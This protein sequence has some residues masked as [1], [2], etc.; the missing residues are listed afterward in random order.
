MRRN[1][2]LTVLGLIALPLLLAAQ[3]RKS[4]VDWQPLLW[5]VGDWTGTG[6]GD[7]GHGSGGF[8]FNQDLQG[9]VLIR[10]SFSEY[11]ATA[12][13]PA[14][15]HDDLM[16]IYPAGKDFRAE[17]FDNEGHVIRYAIAISKDAST[18]TFLSDKAAPGPRFRITYHENSANSLT[19]TFEIAPRDKPNGFTKYLEW[20]AE[21]QVTK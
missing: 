12:G 10:K 11:P 19:G 6:A 8:S 9:H 13:K 14:Y 1:L 16:I 20:T 3:Q 4:E 18:V 15:R 21:K 7:P 5:L 2:G 17:Y